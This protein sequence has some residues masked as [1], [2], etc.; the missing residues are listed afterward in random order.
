VFALWYFLLNIPNKLCKIL[1]LH[2][3]TI[4]ER[5]R[6]REREK[7]RESYGEI[8]MFAQVYSVEGEV[9][10]GDNYQ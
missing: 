10:K 4:N 5:E 2:A 1:V 8:R 7:E 6:E 3:E 9:E